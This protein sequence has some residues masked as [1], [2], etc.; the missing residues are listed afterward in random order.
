MKLLPTNFKGTGTAK[1]FF[2]ELKRFFVSINNARFVM[3]AFYSGEVPTIKL[4]HSNRIEI[5]LKNAYFY[6]PS[7]V[8]VSIS[9]T[10]TSVTQS[11]EDGELVIRI[12]T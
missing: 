3:P 10:Y 4:T 11:C 9:G 7:N 1:E 6:I 5:D 12:E 2:R 8:F